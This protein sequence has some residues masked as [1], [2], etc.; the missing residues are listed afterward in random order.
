[1][2]IV[3]NKKVVK[4]VT[5]LRG[6]DAPLSKKKTAFHLTSLLLLLFASPA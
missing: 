4:Y 1:M 2:Y 5:Q 3:C 6:A